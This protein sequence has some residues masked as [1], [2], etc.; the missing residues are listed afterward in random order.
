VRRLA[1]DIQPFAIA[2][3]GEKYLIAIAAYRL[4]KSRIERYARRP[5]LQRGRAKVLDPVLGGKMNRPRTGVIGVQLLL[6]LGALYA[7]TLG[8]NYRVELAKI[9]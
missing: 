9:E 3:G 8:C 4:R 7:L 6:L 5:V 1:R 2:V